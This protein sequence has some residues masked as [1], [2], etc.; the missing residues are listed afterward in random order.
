VAEL[1]QKRW[2]IEIAFHEL[3]LNL[4]GEIETLGY[5]RA[6]LFGFCVALVCYN[7]LP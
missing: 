6:A 5:P 2:T 3:A 7:P 4:E 1:Y